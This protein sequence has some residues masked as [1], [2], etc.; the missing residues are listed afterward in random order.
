M[1]KPL[2]TLLASAALLTACSG[3]QANAGKEAALEN[4]QSFTAIKDVSPE[5]AKPQDLESLPEFTVIDEEIGSEEFVREIDNPT[6]GDRL[7][8]GTQGIGVVL[9]ET[10]NAATSVIEAFRGLDANILVQE[11]IKEAGGSD[12]RAFVIGERV[13]A[14]MKRTA[15]E[16]AMEW[17]RETQWL[18]WLGA[19]LV[20]GLIEIAEVGGDARPSRGA[21]MAHA[22]FRPSDLPTVMR[23]AHALAESALDGD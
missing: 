2:L 18:W 15:K 9:T 13:V 21:F 23:K 20:L 10:A 6:G 17:L 8:E 5:N 19:A 4:E 16:G 14:A 1:H 7:L 22:D 11:F 12:I 3:E